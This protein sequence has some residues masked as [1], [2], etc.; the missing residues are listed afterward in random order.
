MCANPC[1]KGSSI[2]E[3]TVLGR[4]WSCRVQAIPELMRCLSGIR[5]EGGR[6][7][8]ACGLGRTR[9]SVQD[10]PLCK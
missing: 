2:L 10:L 5:A 7:K 3:S 1:G 6:G 9:G 4:S 8:P